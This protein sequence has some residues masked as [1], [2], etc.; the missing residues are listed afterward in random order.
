MPDTE[1]DQISASLS[2]ASTDVLG[3]MMQVTAT[4]KATGPWAELPPMDTEVHGIVAL[5][6]TVEGCVSVAMPLKT[7]IGLTSKFLG[8]VIQ[9]NS[10]DFDDAMCEITNMIAGGGKSKSNIDGITLGIPSVVVGQS[11]RM[12]HPSGDRARFIL[13]DT[14]TGPMTILITL[15][16]A[17]GSA[18]GEAAARASA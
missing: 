10:A 4:E 6:G 2:S 8:E 7:A 12:A 16:P 14:D 1:L 15:K 11:L 9:P 18:P 13:M 3:M 5:A 17:A